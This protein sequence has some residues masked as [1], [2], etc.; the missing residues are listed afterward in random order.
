M[1]HV[2][3][4]SEVWKWLKMTEGSEGLVGP[5]DLDASLWYL[6]TLQTQPGD[7]E[8]EA[9]GRTSGEYVHCPWKRRSMMKQ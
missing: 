6:P 8:E 9:K 3:R 7:G 4:V 5:L 1:L 2:E